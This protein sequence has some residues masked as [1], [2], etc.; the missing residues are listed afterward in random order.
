ME[1]DF[2]SVSLA[3][4]VLVLQSHPFETPAMTVMLCLG[5]L[6]V[7]AVKEIKHDL[8]HG[9]AELFFITRFTTVDAPLF[10]CPESIQSRVW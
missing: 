4:V 7:N 2:D 10:S 8:E 5:V 3:S 9:C 6:I 1:N